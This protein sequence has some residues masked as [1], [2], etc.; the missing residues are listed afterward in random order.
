MYSKKFRLPLDKTRFRGET[1]ANIP[2]LTLKVK[3][4]AE[5]NRFAIII[6]S[7]AVKKSSRR[8]FWKRIIADTLRDLPNIKKD[9]LVIASK[10]IENSQP[11][12]LKKDLRS[13]ALKFK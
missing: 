5:H 12:V 10:N 6:S 13:A 1:S 8:H 4:G 2:G 3:N 11:S 7:S 9:I